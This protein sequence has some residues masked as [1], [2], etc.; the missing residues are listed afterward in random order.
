LRALIED[1]ATRRAAL[2]TFESHL[3][4]AR[5][6][7][8]GELVLSTATQFPATARSEAIRNQTFM[9]YWTFSADLRAYRLTTSPL[10]EASWIC[11]WTANPR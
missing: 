1:P 11:A 9:L 7:E 4:A 10:S 5:L 2:A 8:T 3:I 6:G